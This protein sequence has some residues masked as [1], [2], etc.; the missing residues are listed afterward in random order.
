M[1]PHKCRSTF[2]F[3]LNLFSKIN[4]CNTV[5]MMQHIINLQRITQKAIGILLI[6]IVDRVL[7][8]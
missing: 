4:A 6:P 1:L 7:T 2:M 8:R 3:D 5:M